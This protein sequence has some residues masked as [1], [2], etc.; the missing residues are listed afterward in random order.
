M[1]YGHIYNNV[2]S[3]Q[4]QIADDEYEDDEFL[5]SVELP[6]DWIEAESDER[7][8]Y[9][10]ATA[11]TTTWVKPVPGLAKADTGF[12]EKLQRE[13]SGIVQPDIEIAANMGSSR[14][15]V[16]DERVFSAIVQSRVEEANV[17]WP[18]RGRVL[19]REGVNKCRCSIFTKGMS[20][21]MN[22]D[23]PQ[24]AVQKL[25]GE[26]EKNEDCVCIIENIDN[27][28]IQALCQADELELPVQFFIKHASL[29]QRAPAVQSAAL[30]LMDD[31]IQRALS[32]ER[33]LER[34]KSNAPLRKIINLLLGA[35]LAV[36]TSI[37]G[38]GLCG[39][40]SYEIDRVASCIV[41]CEKMLTSL[42]HQTRSKSQSSEEASP[43]DT[44]PIQALRRQ[45]RDLEFLRLRRCFNL[46]AAPG[47]PRPYGTA[48]APAF[49]ETGFEL[50]NLQGP[51]EHNLDTR[52]SYI[53][54][55]KNLCKSRI[56]DEKTR[57]VCV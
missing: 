33:T 41:E 19:S 42:K 28:W 20:I 53:R 12:R 32:M 43:I 7:D 13:F 30:S 9:V 47:E 37:E 6:P 17:Q 1:H 46:K 26:L 14:S 48:E 29:D 49:D 2:T 36:K 35:N 57:N 54:V 40:T 21:P 3:I 22:D 38:W 16:S 39:V 55:D 31:I 50:Q 11:G 25:V 56:Q 45:M 5:E 34:K 8:Y 4:N 51:E 27:D 10:D 15:T 24:V 52:V 18:N 23:L 44:Y